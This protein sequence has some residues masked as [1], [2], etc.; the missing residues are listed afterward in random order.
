MKKMKKIMKEK[1]GAMYDEKETR[2]GVK[3]EEV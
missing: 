3:Y 1:M 2:I